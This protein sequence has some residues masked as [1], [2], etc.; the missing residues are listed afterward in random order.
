MN[1]VFF[2]RR[3]LVGNFSIENLFM[4]I[5][6]AL[7]NEIQWNKKELSFYSKGFF[8]RFF[9]CLEAMMNQREINHITGDI[10]FI[11]IFLRGS[12]TVLTIHDIGYM[13]HQNPLARLFLLWFWIKLPVTKSA[14]VTTVSL[15]TKNE[16]LRYI[17]IRPD[18]VKVIYVPVSPLFVPM[19]KEFNKSEPTI[20]QIGTKKNKNIL[21]LIK[22]LKGINCKLEI[23]GFLD[24]MIKNELKESGVKYVSSVNLSDQEIVKKYN[25]ADIISFA[26]TYEGF[27]I[28]IVE[29]N[30]IGRVVV[31]SNI[32]SM[33]EVAGD[34]AHLVDPFDVTSIREGILKVISDD[35]YR[36]RLISNG[37]INKSRFEL[38]TIAEQYTSIYKSLINQ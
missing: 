19:P 27:G 38:T 28:P 17:N 11:S 35:D 25:A 36:E 22:A 13:N 24:D 15:A 20:L 6:G 3:R 37:Y 32:L 21:R 31:T 7:P 33:L 26:S 9:I 2:Y 5:C 12:R 4:Q 18:K 8:S 34:A 30:A 10:N 29:G 14:C 16:L 1:V 23:V